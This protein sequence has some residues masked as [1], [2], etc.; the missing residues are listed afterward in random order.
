VEKG[1]HAA[2]SN[3]HYA[4][5]I[6][7]DGDNGATATERVAEKSHH[8]NSDHSDKSNRKCASRNG[9][10]NEDMMNRHFEKP[11]TR[12]K[13]ASP[14]SRN[15]SKIQQRTSRKLT[16]AKALEEARRQQSA[17]AEVLSAISSSKFE[18]QPVLDRVVRSAA[19]LCR[20]RQGLI[21]RFEDGVY[22]FAAGYSINPAY[23]A[24]E[25]RSQISPGPGTLVGRA[26]MA[27]RAVRID[28][29]WADPLYERKE[30]AKVGR[31]RSMLGVPLLR[32]GEPI[33]VIGLSRSRVD[34]FSAREIELITT[35]ANQAVIAIENVRLLEAEQQRTRELTE[36]LEQQTAAAEVL[37]V[38]S[39]SPGE[40]EPVFATMLEK[41]V[42]ICGATFG[43][44]Y[45][46]DGEALHIVATHN[47]P[48]A[49][50]EERRR[51]PYYPDPKSP[52]GRMV[53]AKTPMLIRDV[54][55]EDAYLA[56]RDS[57]A[58]AAVELGGA[59]TVLSVPLLDK[60]EM[61][62]AFFLCRQRVQS[63][64]DKQIKVVQH[65]ATQ[66]VI[67]IESARLLNELGERTADLTEA[68]GQQKAITGVLQ[69]LSDSSGKLE[70]IFQAILESAVDI[71]RAHFGNMFLYED[72]AFRGVAMFN[73]P[74]A[75]AKARMTAP[76]SR[77]A[78][79]GLGRLVATKDVVQ[80]EDLLGDKTYLKGDPFA[81]A[82]VELAGIR[83]LLAV[84]MLK[85]DQL[86]GC[87]IIYR[88]EPRP[89][90]EKQI[91]LVKNFASQVVLG[92]ENAR[93][94]N[95]LRD[96]TS[97]LERSYTLVQQQ[98][99]QLDVQ[100]R[101][102]R[103]LN[104]GL[105]ERVDEQVSEIERMSRPGVFCLRKLPI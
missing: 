94:L 74:E 81:I 73:A 92:L 85:D 21:F 83:T 54:M 87:I 32:D 101:E 37:Q 8:P 99:S 72:G 78:D 96:R 19:R 84:P 64:T 40:L 27:R 2:R 82:G 33:G 68:L 42:R 47:T 97:E 44:I 15:K 39:R 59:R 103:K 71:C 18:L 13:T 52:V 65:F 3:T 22:R 38:I 55:A 67:A 100:A 26:A 61:T 25:R 29:A 57:G 28:D 75:Y 48:P 86:V 98:A 17:L 45:R 58:V 63:F 56:R 20:A 9:L 77:P 23:S 7:P 62:G 51:S 4:V 36:A 10:P 11:E 49:F 66:A 1:A 14:K 89:F 79:S 70:P 102:L 5:N 105:E 16:G 6:C 12:R 31:H 34:P 90:S 88:Q 30:D 43:N 95:E 104:E 69:M 35:F 93:L 46:W 91:Q 24:I 60:G 80:I 53:A 41:A 76:F 50:A